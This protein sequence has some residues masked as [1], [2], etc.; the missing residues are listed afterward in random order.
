MHVW[1][2]G[3]WERCRRTKRA[4]TKRRLAERM[5][6]CPVG[7]FSFSSINT[8]SRQVTRS[9]SK[10]SQGT[11]PRLAIVG[12]NKKL[13]QAKPSSPSWCAPR[14]AKVGCFS[15]LSSGHQARGRR[16]T[17]MPKQSLSWPLW[18]LW[19]L[20]SLVFGC[21]VRGRAK[22][23]QGIVLSF[24][25]KPAFAA[26]TFAGKKASASAGWHGNH[27]VTPQEEGR[28]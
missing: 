24:H 16:V 2:K 27:E 9:M 11:F 10:D 18:L 26:E 21:L 23:R 17:V 6:P 25:R 8:L 20:W 5:W 15:E 19:A 13:K 22:Q 3:P 12:P 28:G 7:G 14:K 1:C 4:L